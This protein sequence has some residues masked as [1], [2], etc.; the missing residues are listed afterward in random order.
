MTEDHPETTEITGIPEIRRTQGTHPTDEITETTT[1]TATTIAHGIDEIH[2]QKNPVTHMIQEAPDTLKT[3]VAPEGRDHGIDISHLH[4][5]QT[6]LT[7]IALGI[8]PLRLNH[9]RNQ[10]LNPH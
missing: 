8:E 1:V 10:H 3:S 7:D 2:P 9:L 5:K 4:I 6:I